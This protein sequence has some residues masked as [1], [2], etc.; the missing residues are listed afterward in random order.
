LRDG[1]LDTG[2]DL[3]TPVVG[4]PFTAGLFQ[5]LVLLLRADSK[6]P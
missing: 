2:A 6:L 1:P 3:V 5:R 4:E